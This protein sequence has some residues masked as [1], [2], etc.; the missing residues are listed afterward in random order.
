M[1]PPSR[2]QAAVSAHGMESLIAGRCLIQPV[3]SLVEKILQMLVMLTYIFVQMY[4]PQQKPGY[5]RS[6]IALRWSDISRVY[7]CW[8]LI[9]RGVLLHGLASG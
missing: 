5:F 9:A 1:A 7:L 4:H 6:A 3:S 2:E 8:P